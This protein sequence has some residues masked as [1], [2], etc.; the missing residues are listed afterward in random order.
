[1]RLCILYDYKKL[2]KNAVFTYLYSKRKKVLIK[3]T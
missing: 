1:M 3:I 2:L